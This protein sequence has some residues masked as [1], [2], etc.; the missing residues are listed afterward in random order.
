MIRLVP[1]LSPFVR[2]CRRQA[3]DPCDIRLQIACRANDPGPIVRIHING[4]N[5]F[6]LND[7]KITLM[8]IVLDV[9]NLAKSKT[10]G[11]KNKKDQANQWEDSVQFHRSQRILI[12]A[13]MIYD[14]K[15]PVQV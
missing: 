8:R 4:R 7:G 12:A 11:D 3:R 14:A 5:G 2:H 13:S 10:V 9:L 6:S 15:V 1:G